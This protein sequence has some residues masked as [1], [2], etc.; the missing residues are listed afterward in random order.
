[1]TPSTESGKGRQAGDWMCEPGTRSG[2]GCKPGNCGHVNLI[3]L[4]GRIITVQTLDV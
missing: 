3:S 1:M 4:S 2:K